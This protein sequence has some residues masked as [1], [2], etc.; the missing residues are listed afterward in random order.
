MWFESRRRADPATDRHSVMWYRLTSI[1]MLIVVGITGCRTLH[2]DQR[3]DSIPV[4]MWFGLAT[5]DKD[6]RNVTPP[7]DELV[8]AAL[9][10]AGIP[11]TVDESGLH[12]APADEERA[13]EALLMDRRLADSGVIVMVAVPAGTGRKTANG[14]EFTAQSPT[15]APSK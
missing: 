14:I 3:E 7:R 8:I 9:K 4:A 6:G 12:V 10:T 5:V 11:A 1:A 15:T 2:T 13:R